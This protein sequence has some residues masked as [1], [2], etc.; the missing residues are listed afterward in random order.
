M[1]MATK[2]TDEMGKPVAVRGKFQMFKEKDLHAIYHVSKE[3]DFDANDNI[4]EGDRYEALLIGYVADISNLGFAFDLAEQT[5][6]AEA[7]EYDV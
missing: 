5:M 7:G 3:W 2:Y 4:V 6:R 1:N